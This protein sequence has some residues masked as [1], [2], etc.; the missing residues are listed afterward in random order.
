MKNENEKSAK[1]KTTNLSNLMTIF[2]TINKADGDMPVVAGIIKDTEVD[3][4]NIPA[5]ELTK[6]I[7]FYSIEGLLNINDKNEINICCITLYPLKT[8]AKKENGDEN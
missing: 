1:L 6:Y 3:L 2:K 4:T 7:D 8:T 5:N